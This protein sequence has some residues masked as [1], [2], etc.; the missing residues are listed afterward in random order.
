MWETVFA[1]EVA[2]TTN[3]WFVAVFSVYKPYW[4]VNTRTYNEIMSNQTVNMCLQLSN[5]RL[6][7]HKSV[8]LLTFIYIMS[9][10]MRFLRYINRIFGLII[11]YFP[12]FRSTIQHDKKMWAISSCWSLSSSQLYTMIH[13]QVWELTIFL[14]E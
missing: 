1:Y 13:T 7:I 11:F 10:S 8:R 9:F 4:N 12:N 5:I 3:E 2:Y 6:V 14:Q